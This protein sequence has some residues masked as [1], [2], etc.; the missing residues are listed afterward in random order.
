MPRPL[1][2]ASGGFEVASL[3][4]HTNERLGV[5]NDLE[6]EITN[7][8]QEKSHRSRN[9]DASQEIHD[10]NQL[11]FDITSANRRSS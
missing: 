5:T 7:T 4:I 8:Q 9:P 2:L 1:H 11:S 10:E 6:H 3:R